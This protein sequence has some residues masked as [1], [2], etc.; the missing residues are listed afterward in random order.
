MSSE[1]RAFVTVDRGTATTAVALVGR[2]DGRWRLLGATSGPVEVP[3]EALV[4]RLRRRL[5][6]VDPELAASLLIHTDG[7]AEAMP[8]ISCATA[9]PPEIAVV[10]ATHRALMPLSATARE[11]G[12]QVVP[13][14]LEG[15]QI[16]T[17]AATLA[18][19]RLSAVL[20]GAGDPPGGDERPLMAELAMQV[21]AAANRRPDLT[22][23]LTGSLA[24]PGGRYEA[25][26]RQDRVGATIVGPSPGAAG[27]GPLRRLLD[28]IRSGDDDGRRALGVATATLAEVLRRSVGVVEVGQSSGMRAVA[29]HA[30]GAP[31]Q[32]EVAIVADAALLP[33]RFTDGHLDAIAGWLPV[34]LDRLRIRDRLRELAMSPWGDAAGEGAAL[35]LAAA[36][37]AVQRLAAATHRLDG[38]RPA[39]TVAVGGVWSAVPAPLTAL[40]LADVLRR[41]GFHAF[42]IDHARLLA[43]LGTIADADERRQLM[44][45]LCDELVAPLGSVVMPAG[46]RPGRSAGRLVLHRATSDTTIDLVPGGIERVE[47]A[48]G[49]RAIAEL[50]LREALDLG[51]RTRRAAA[52]IAG[53]LVGLLVD[54]RDVPL[55]LPE[56]PERRR[57][58]LTAWERVVW[59][60]AAR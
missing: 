6:A 59:P 53:G 50:E 31:S 9:A 40:A 33:R 46:F 8:R 7:A 57:D 56:R 27:G 19:P 42:G 38:A 39:V 16:T 18:N 48:P 14:T 3:P 45:D 32:V 29:D 11:T 24:E 58:V 55:R 28:S 60:A 23:I 4:E 20:A 1:P 26:L 43:P 15:A 47:L 44:A 2:V 17:V 25:S 54:L 36:R 35:R 21:G 10:A 41:P 13:V 49:E 5:C 22:M 34:P 30:P 52:E 12:W 37:A 51:V